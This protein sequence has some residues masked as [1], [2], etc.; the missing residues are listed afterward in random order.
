[1][2]TPLRHRTVSNQARFERVGPLNAVDDP[3]K[4][5]KARYNTYRLLMSTYYATWVR[6]SL[7][8]A[9]LGLGIH[10][11]QYRGFIDSHE[12][13]GTAIISTCALLLTS[14]TLSYL[15]ENLKLNKIETGN[16]WW[17]TWQAAATAI[18]VVVVSVA[19]ALFVAVAA[20]DASR[21]MAL[22]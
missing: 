7:L 1:M 18:Y 21:T 20:R 2:D 19:F 3:I 6:N 15:Y 4:V 10:I 11:G 16:N 5:Q 17:P 9:S 14:S 12:W 8:G 22:R 13:L